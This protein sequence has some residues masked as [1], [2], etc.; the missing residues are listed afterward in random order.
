MSTAAAIHKG[1]RLREVATFIDL[2]LL[3]A[4]TVLVGL[5]LVMVASASLHKYSGAP[6]Y[7][8]VRHAVAIGLGLAG[9][10]V[11]MM[12]PVRR[13]EQWSAMLYFA[14]LAMLMRISSRP[15]A[16]PL[17]AQQYRSLL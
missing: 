17:S 4:A 5:G 11:V 14:G 10:L 6:L 15:K 9:S 13:W 1:S 3:V 8:T 2:R 16:M 7:F 12:I